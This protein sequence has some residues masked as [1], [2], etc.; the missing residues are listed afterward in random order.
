LEGN[1]T[2][3]AHDGSTS[4]LINRYRKARAAQKRK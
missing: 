3:L 4:N 1:G 2:E